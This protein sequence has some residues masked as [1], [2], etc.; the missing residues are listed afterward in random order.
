[1]STPAATIE[2]L[3]DEPDHPSRGWYV[4]FAEH[5]AEDDDWEGPFESYE[6]AEEYAKSIIE[7]ATVAAIEAMFK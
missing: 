3:Y 1:M 6:A 7:A 2:L 5:P 4:S